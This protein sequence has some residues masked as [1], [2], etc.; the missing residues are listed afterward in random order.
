MP[1]TIRTIKHMREDV[2]ALDR[3]ELTLRDEAKATYDKAREE[4]RGLSETEKSRDAEIK[5]SLS[6]IAASRESLSAEIENETRR[7]ELE[8]GSVKAERSSV[9]VRCSVEDDPKRG[10]ETFGHFALDVMNAGPGIDGIRSNPR[11]MAAAG[12]GMTQGVTVEG[13]VLM[14]PAFSTA[15]WDGA[16][17]AS[18]SL[19]QY[20]DVM[21]VDPGVQ[22][23][24]IPAIN[25]TSRVA[26]SRWGGVRGYW[27]SEL[28]AM[29][30]SRP[31][32]REVKLEP[33]ELYVLAYASDKLLRHAPGA[34]SAILARAAADEI[35]F[36]VGDS[37]INGDGMGKPRGVIGHAATVSITKE[38]GQAAATI[39]KNNIDKMWARCHANWRSGA[40]WFINQDCEPQLEALAADVGTGGVP[41]YLPAGGIADTPNARLKG[42]PVVAI[43]YCPTLGTVGDIILANLGA[44]AVGMRGMVD[45]SSSMHLKFDYAQTA[46]RFIFEV[47]GQ[48][49]L[50]STLTPFKGSNTLSPIVTL[51]TRA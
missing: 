32:F 46:F 45:Q 51:N 23:I 5:A 11:L 26:G 47:D 27:K 12:T 31:A 43:E 42:R 49:W 34:A 19:L 4:K 20:C 39:V 44:Y 36:L 22:S 7:T 24:S 48:P 40:V 21:P 38:T 15:I 9:S 13:G 30:E 28:T 3:Q 6:G 41:V 25:E 50:A 18:N 14:P 33:Q 29:T 37:I 16:R 35:N 8:K 1:A 10:Y 17:T 2:S